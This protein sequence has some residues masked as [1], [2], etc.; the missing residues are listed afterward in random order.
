M[1][2]PEWENTKEIDWT[3]EK[4]AITG[5]GQMAAGYVAVLPAV[6]YESVW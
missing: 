1:E 5:G 4:K 6:C 3:K 2:K